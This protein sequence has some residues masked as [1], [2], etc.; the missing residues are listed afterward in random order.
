MIE[1]FR[2]QLSLIDLQFEGDT[3][4]IRKAVYQPVPVV[5]GLNHKPFDLIPKRV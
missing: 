4:L 3:D 1:R 5:G 2:K